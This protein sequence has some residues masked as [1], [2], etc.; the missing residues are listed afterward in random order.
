MLKLLKLVTVQNDVQSIACRPS[1][2]EHLL[3]SNRFGK[4]LMY[5]EVD[6]NPSQLKKH[7]VLERAERDGGKKGLG[8]SLSLR[9][10][11]AMFSPL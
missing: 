9:A 2:P 10:R 7:I 8:K 3:I 11:R 1:P 4:I 5:C 6:P